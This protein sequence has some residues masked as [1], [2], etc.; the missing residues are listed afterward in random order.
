MGAGEE[1]GGKDEGGGKNA[2]VRDP[3]FGS[4]RVTMAYILMCACILYTCVDVVALHLISFV[5]FSFVF[6]FFISFFFAI[7]ASAKVLHGVCVDARGPKELYVD[8]CFTAHFLY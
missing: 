4:H 5:I 8:C 7:F 2:R 1:G 6:F 3:I